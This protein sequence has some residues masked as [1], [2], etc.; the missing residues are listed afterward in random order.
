MS[1]MFSVVTPAPAQSKP[2]NK[3][4]TSAA[5]PAMPPAKPSGPA[6]P[7]VPGTPPTV[8]VVPAVAPIVLSHPVA[9]ITA[10]A[11]SP[12]G[13][14]CA[15]GTYGQVVM[16]DTA[17]WQVLAV[18]RG[19]EDSV[20]SL[21]FS[22]DGQTLAIG[23]GLP[24]LDGLALTWD[25]NAASKTVAYP[26][27]KDVIESVAFRRDGKGLL[28]GADDNKVR[29]FSSLPTVVGATLDEHNG[30]VQAV[31][32]SPKPDT[33]F[34]SGG[35]DRIVKVWDQKS[36][37]TVINFDQSEGGITGLAFIND[38][39]FVGSS[40]DGKLYWWGVSYDTK[41]QTYSG[42]P[43][44]TL[45]AHDGGV[46]ALNISNDTSRL[47]TA[48]MDKSVIVWKQDGNRV[49]EF[50]G[51]AQPMYA[52][53][54]SPD[55][56]TAMWGGREG[57]LYVYDVDGNKIVNNLLPPALPKPPLPK[58]SASAKTERTDVKATE[59]KQVKG[60]RNR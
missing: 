16:Y 33:I 34:I 26:K 57:I 47:I 21:A 31:A 19:V 46:L 53:A 2:E 54:L 42:Y 3:P 6:V 14:R 1:S 48:G 43:F 45:G 39:Q 5:K 11:V 9:A 50:K 49:R 51:L 30:R 20:R 59:E 52:V 23:C 55:G 17:S 32:F 8:P 15:L 37:H 22:P 24:G 7:A 40:L 13:K 10:L 18:T 58:P 38:G 25:M 27:Q 4:V 44:R 28:C 35:L 29:Y 56:K 12:D 60:K 36:A 41:K